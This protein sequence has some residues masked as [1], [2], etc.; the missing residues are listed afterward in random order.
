MERTFPYRTVHMDFHTG[1]DIPD[2]G[3]DFDPD[4]F[5]SVLS[6]ANI[7]SVTLFAKCH[8]GLLYYAT[9]R[10][11]RHPGLPRDLDLLRAQVDALHARGIRAPIY[12]SV[13]CDEWAA[14]SHPDWVAMEP[15]G[16]PVKWGGPFSA[17]WQIL[18][19][20]S[21]YQDFLAEQLD[22]IL[23][24]FAPVDGIFMDMC[25]DQPSV[26]KWAR[27][28]M[29]RRGYDPREEADRRRYAHEVSLA[30]MERYKEMLDHAQGAAPPVGMWFNG[31]PKVGLDAERHCLR[32]V[33][34]ECLPTGGWGYA[35]FPFVARYVRPIGLPTLS[36]TGR[37]HGSWGDFGGLKPEAAMKYECCLIL[38][39]GMTNG[40]GDQLHPRG[41]LEPSVY[42]QIGRV[43]GHVRACEPWVADAR[44]AREAAVIVDPAT[45]DQPGDWGLGLVRALQ[46]LRV[47]FD[48]LP[49]TADI[50]G[51][52]L[53]I[54]PEVVSID[55]ALA[56]SLRAHL[57]GGGALIALGEAA[58]AADG[59]AALPELG[60]QVEGIS[61][62]TATYLRAP[63]LPA[64]AGMDHVMHEIGVRLRPI[65]G[66]QS[67]CTVVEPYFERA[68][69]HFCSHRQTPA[70]DAAPWSALV[71]NGRCATLAHPLFTA[72]GRHGNL[73][74]REL[75][76][77]ALDRVLPDRLVRDSGPSHL[78]ATVVERTDSVVV[79]LLSYAPVRR[80]RDLDLIEEPFPLIDTSISVRLP[81]P[82]RRALLAPSGA[83]LPF[84]WSEGRAEVTVTCLDGHTMVVFESDLR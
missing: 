22:E 52:P 7:D 82:P 11:E 12:V 53:V 23:R 66:A 36:H 64:L 9:D 84:T 74:Y 41:A 57:A 78:E 6:D 24:Q 79:H 73:P 67:L 14:N 15:D 31:R 16:R 48:L 42:A 10:P 20:S 21:P 47:Q 29:R 18:D 3:R 35:F 77:A 34:I 39:Q 60:I 46:Q 69:D 68:W 30:Y 38:S 56:A 70:A 51:Y 33:E 5:A 54:V 13:Q 4:T 45:G 17:G 81:S 72:Y 26:T 49:P 8:H 27:D 61:P 55:H 44:H 32:H 28:G 59:G 25:W 63:D 1:P 83:E 58:V 75:L 43:Y 19:M 37:F 71:V 2:V 65:G 76:R 50:A 40:I 62:Y 80:T